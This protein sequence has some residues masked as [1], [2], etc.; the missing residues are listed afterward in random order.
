M[1]PPPSVAQ[2]A[3]A[4]AAVCAQVAPLSADEFAAI[5]K[6][7]VGNLKLADVNVAVSLLN[8]CLVR[9]YALLARARLPADQQR[10]T[11]D[12]KDRL[13]AYRAQLSEHCSRTRTFVV[14]QEFRQSL[15]VPALAAQVPKLRQ[16]LR[17]ARRIEEIRGGNQCRLA[18]IT[19]E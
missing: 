9:K 12:E 8:K 1:P 10:M 18:V 6:Y 4:P 17:T 13:V 2:P 7:Q 15:N 14:E 16:V 3:A 19:A 5:P 11:K